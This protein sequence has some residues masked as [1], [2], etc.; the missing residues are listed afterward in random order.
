[1]PNCFTV[2]TGPARSGKTERLLACYRTGLMGGPIGSALWLSPTQR[3]AA[4]VRG[5]LLD[6]ALQGC[7]RPGI[8]TFEK[9]AESVLQSTGIPIRLI[10]KL[11]KRELVR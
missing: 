10:T 7:F 11:M 2:L 9:F 4:E 6:G 5:R 1:M 8:M 3:T